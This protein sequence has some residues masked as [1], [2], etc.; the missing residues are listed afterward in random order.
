MSAGEQARHDPGL[1]AVRRVRA[2]RETDSRIGLKHALA[3]LGERE[4]EAAR[5]QEKL[6]Q[7]PAFDAGSTADFAVHRQHLG[8]LARDKQVTETAAEDGRTVADEATRRWQADTTSVRAVEMLLQRRADERAAERARRE[9][10]ELDDLAA[11]GWQR[12]QAEQDPHEEV[13]R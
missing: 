4:A 5:A 6:E 1:N 8:N 10:R 11:Q 7:A 12:L 2:A 3:A 13:V 9:A